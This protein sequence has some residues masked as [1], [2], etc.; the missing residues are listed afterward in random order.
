MVLPLLG[1]GAWSSGCSHQ[2]QLWHMPGLTQM[3]GHPKRQ[4][5][6]CSQEG[7][8][9]TS[10]R[11]GVAVAL[12]FLSCSLP[13]LHWLQVSSVHTLQPIPRCAAWDGC[14]SLLLTGIPGFRLT[15]LARL[16]IPNPL[17][18]WQRVHP[19]LLLGSAFGT[20]CC[21][22]VPVVGTQKE[23]VTVNSPYST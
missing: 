19:I 8:P 23:E 7:F 6:P 21:S 1:F 3:E 12:V 13:S 11:V 5:S 4:R 20:S 22:V 17:S 16:I 2:L 18:L 14:F 15:C 10:P 9:G